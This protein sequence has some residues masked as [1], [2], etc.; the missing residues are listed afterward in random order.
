[1]G[2]AIQIYGLGHHMHADKNIT[3]YYLDVRLNKDL[4]RLCCFLSMLSENYSNSTIAQSSRSPFQQFLLGCLLD[5]L[6]FPKCCCQSWSKTMLS[7]SQKKSKVLLYNYLHLS[8]ISHVGR[9]E[10]SFL[11]GLELAPDRPNRG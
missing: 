10:S 1:M 3:R 6:G 11:V 5:Q 2:K 7:W 8:L 9:C 4:R